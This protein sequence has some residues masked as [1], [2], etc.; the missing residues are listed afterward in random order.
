M[1]GT[2]VKVI[3]RPKVSQHKNVFSALIFTLYW[4]LQCWVLSQKS[5]MCR[6]N[7]SYPGTDCW[8]A[9]GLILCRPDRVSR[10]ALCILFNEHVGVF[11]MVW[12]LRSRVA[13]MSDALSSSSSNRT[14]GTKVTVVVEPCAPSRGQDNYGSRGLGAVNAAWGRRF[15]WKSR[16]MRF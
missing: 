3:V 15:N 16:M 1:S 13:P 9:A 10:P 8:A 14:S 2:K 6:G 12:P 4:F 7:P 5:C 11:L